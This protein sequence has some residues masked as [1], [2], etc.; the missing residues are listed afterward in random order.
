MPTRLTALY[1][2]L[3]LMSEVVTGFFIS[4]LVFIGVCTRVLS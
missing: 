4:F 2:Q 3:T 1:D